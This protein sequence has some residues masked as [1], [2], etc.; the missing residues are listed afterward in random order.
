MSLFKPIKG[1]TEKINNTPI[2]EGQMLL[3]VELNV[4]HIDIDN[5]TRRSYKLSLLD[6]ISES[7]TVNT[8]TNIPITKQSVYAVITANQSLTIPDGLPDSMD[9]RVFVKADNA[10][11][12]VT[13]AESATRVV[14]GDASFTLAANEWLEVHVTSV[15]GVYLIRAAGQ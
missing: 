14:L 10:T 12:T 3:D 2:K 9:V 6:F 8:L 1:N 13:I 5:E 15:G 4:L 11:R 7:N